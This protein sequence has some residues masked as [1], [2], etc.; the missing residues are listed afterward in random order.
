MSKPGK[1]SNNAPSQ[2]VTAA[3]AAVAASDDLSSD[4]AADAYVAPAFAS[5][6]SFPS[7][8][9][10][11]RW[12]T[13]ADA[14]G[15]SEITNWV[16]RDK[17]CVGECPL[18]RGDIALLAQCN[19][20]CYVSL[21][22][23]EEMRAT[24]SMPYSGI[25]A[26]QQEE[27][28]V[29]DFLHYPIGDMGCPTDLDTCLALVAEI[30]LRLQRG[31][32]IY[33]HCRGG[34]GRTGLLVSVLM[35]AIDPSLTTDAALDLCQTL[36]RARKRNGWGPSPETE[37][38]R[39]CVRQLVQRLRTWGS[40]TAGGKHKATYKAPRTFQLQRFEAGTSWTYMATQEPT[41]K[42]HS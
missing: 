10:F 6:S 18:Q 11:G 3:A 8:P 5:S 2:P 19:F 39:E 21:M 1:P 22:E 35:A 16:I 37:A 7:W 34:H 20:N 33:I 36:H 14:P 27:S 40:S 42:K 38:Q 23:L 28:A 32:K 31:D 4:A 24:R 13:A 41:K 12:C 9:S 17:L 30:V 25:I 15:P 29:L 26:L